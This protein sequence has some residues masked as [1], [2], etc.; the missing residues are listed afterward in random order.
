[1]AGFPVALIFPCTL[2]CD[3]EGCKSEQAAEA[4]Y[5]GTSFSFLVGD[6]RPTPPFNIRYTPAVGLEWKITEHG[7]VACS[8]T[9]HEKLLRS[10][11]NTK[12]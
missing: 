10:S 2:R 8:P 12:E 1:M 6:T 11:T 3:G 4:V 7:K 5:G 9:C